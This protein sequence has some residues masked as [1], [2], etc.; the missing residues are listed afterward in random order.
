MNILFNEVFLNHNKDSLAE[1]AYRIKKFPSRYK[2]QSLDG[3]KWINLI[4]SER[5]RESIKAACE[6]E[7]IVA[8]VALNRDSYQA[9][10]E[11]VGL[12]VK[13]SQ[14]SGFAV[15]RPPGHHAGVSHAAGFCFFNN[16]AIASQRLVDQGKRVFIFDFDGHHGDGTQAIFYESD[17]VFYCSVHQL[18]AYPFTG[19]ITETGSGKGQGYTLNLP[20]LAG[21]GDDKFLKAVDQAIAA[22]KTFKP[23]MIAISAGFDAYE[24]DS[25]LSLDIT[26]KAFYECGFRWRRAFPRLFAVLEGGYHE[27][28]LECVETFVDGVNVGGRPRKNLYDTDMSV[29]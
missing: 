14:Q 9:A 29:G 4:H 26:Q 12:T 2:N 10:I 17:Q 11:A 3:E 8:E 19:F 13:A 16:I 5:Y 27:D 6:Q 1:G 24:K 28:L 23:D 21:S 20:L 18:Y 15:V 25:L 22:A 7:E